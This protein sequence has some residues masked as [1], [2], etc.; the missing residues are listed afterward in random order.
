MIFQT[1]FEYVKRVP[2]PISVDNIDADYYRPGGRDRYLAKMANAIK[3]TSADVLH[4]MLRTTNHYLVWIL[5]KDQWAGFKDY[6]KESDLEQFVY[7]DMGKFVTNHNYRD[8]GR[9]LRL[10]IMQGQGESE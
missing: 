4:E 9:R 1:T 10:V 2:S 5:T 7:F 8:L 3:A 6:I